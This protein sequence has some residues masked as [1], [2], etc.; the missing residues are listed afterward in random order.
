[1]GRSGSAKWPLLGQTFS[2]TWLGIKGEVAS[3]LLVV[4]LYLGYLKKDQKRRT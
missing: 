1:M 2:P 3:L 4:L